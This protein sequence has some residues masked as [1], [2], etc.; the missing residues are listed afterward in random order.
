MFAQA[1]QLIVDLNRD[2]DR[3][4]DRSQNVRLDRNERTEPFNDKIFK[5]VVSLISS[6]DLVAYPDQHPLYNTLS[7]FLNVDTGNILLTP[8]SDAGLKY[9]FETFVREGDAVGYLWPT[10][11]M[12]D[13]YASM[14]GAQKV[15]FNHDP[16]L[17]LDLQ[18][19]KSHIVNRTIKLLILA[20]PNQ[21]T[22][23]VIEESVMDE[24]VYLAEK[25]G[26]KLVLD[27]AYIDFSNS[28]DRTEEVKATRNLIIMRTFSKGYGL[29]GL[30][31][32]YLL[33]A[34]DNIDVL[35]KVKSCHDINIMAL[36]TAQYMTEHQDIL[37]D[38]VQEIKSSKLLLEE[39]CTENNIGFTNSETNFI[40]IKGNLDMPFIK[41]RMADFGYLLRF[42]GDGLPAVL[43][44]SIRI[45]L[46][47][48]PQIKEFLNRLK[49]VMEEQN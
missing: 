7:K 26:I 2:Y 11:A 44:D 34:R 3:G 48:T 15:I 18:D 13:V 12:I 30:R 36:K 14:Y 27:Q 22:G 1:N 20:N 33:S 16:N 19:I 47:P 9:I 49:T 5:D 40:H 4:L 38:Y 6:E 46:G 21:P 37:G 23:T 45:T 24:L 10:Y 42:N 32:G 17:N 25:N 29:A 41:K 8:G 39:F 43:E 28:S 35:Y 31:I